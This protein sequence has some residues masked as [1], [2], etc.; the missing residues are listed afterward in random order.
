MKKLIREFSILAAPIMFVAATPV[1]AELGVDVTLVELKK[2][3]SGSQAIEADNGYI[4]FHSPTRAIANFIKIPDEADEAEFREEW[5]KEFAKAEK[6]YPRKYAKWRT[7]VQIANATR[8]PIPEKPVEPTRENFSIGNILFRNVVT[9]GPQYK[10]GADDAEQEYSYLTAVEPGTYIYY[11][12]IMMNPV[13]GTCACMGTV[14]FEVK[15]GVITDIGNFPVLAG[16]NDQLKFG[17]P[18]AL[19]EYQ[20]SEADFRAYGK[21]DNQYGVRIGRVPA[22]DGVMRYERDRMID[23]KVEAEAEAVRDAAI[24]GSEDSAAS[25]PTATSTETEAL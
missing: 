7:D 8:K 15:P 5:E 4:F 25:V 6:K 10:F 14:K 9:V 22:L 13:A 19:A 21:I 17:L 11:G 3:E 12:G 1:H 16:D 2:L 20:S 24:G 18:P 23:L